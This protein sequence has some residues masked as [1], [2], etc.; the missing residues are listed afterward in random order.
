MAE[1]CRESGQNM[2]GIGAEDA[3]ILPTLL[4][5]DIGDLNAAKAAQPEKYFKPIALP[6]GF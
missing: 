6:P 1:P 4:Q 2:L 3:S 5:R